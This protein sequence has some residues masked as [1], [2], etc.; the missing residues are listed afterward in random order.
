MTPA[1]DALHAKL[2]EALQQLENERKA[3]DKKL[4]QKEREIA[5]LKARLRKAQSEEEVFEAWAAKEREVR[6]TRQTLAELDRKALRLSLCLHLLRE[7]IDAFAQEFLAGDLIGEMG[8]PLLQ[9]LENE[10]KRL[11]LELHDGPAQWIAGAILRMELA[12]KMIP[13]QQ[14]AQEELKVAEDLARKSLQEL[15]HFI[16]KLRPMSLDDM[17]LLPTVRNYLKKFAQRSGIQVTASIDDLKDTFPSALEENLFRII[18]EALNNVEKHAEATSV[19]LKVV[20]SADSLT[21]RVQD[22]GKGFDAEQALADRKTKQG[23]GL[24]SMRER[25]ALL[26]GALGIESRPG[27]GTVLQVKIPLRRG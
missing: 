14:Q 27:E 8:I 4:K 16:F 13:T 9:A 22:D 18:Q 25:A 1:T 19:Q 2:E 24:L 6:K 17:E 11:T 15:R 21:L 3:W 20:K 5:E 26:G 12:A 23:L 10:R 7:E